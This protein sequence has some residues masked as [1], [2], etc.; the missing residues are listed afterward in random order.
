MNN[1][2]AK[3]DGGKIKPSLVP[4][5]IIRAIARV[6]EYGV[7]KYGDSEC[8]QQ[9]EPERYVDAAYRH[10]LEYIDNRKSVDAESHLPHLWHLACNIAFLIALEAEDGLCSQRNRQN[11]K[12]DGEKDC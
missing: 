7:D 4:T 1:Q 9:I 11:V 6:R 5:D 3:Y 2:A 8:W 10:F 12:A